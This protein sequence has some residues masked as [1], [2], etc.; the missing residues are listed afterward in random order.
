MQGHNAAM[1][2]GLSAVYIKVG[3]RQ[4]FEMRVL[5]SAIA[6]V[7]LGSC[8]VVESFTEVQSQAEAA[9]TVLEKE[10]G[11]KPA[12][13]WNIHNAVLTNVNVIFDVTKVSQL[14]VGELE[15]RVQKAVAGN[16][17]LQPKQLIVGVQR[18]L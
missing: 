1:K 6:V 3:P 8:N 9:A 16:F 13:G 7:L 10:L 4:E 15:A 12:V 18:V 11:T 14:S 5:L 17:K 2:R